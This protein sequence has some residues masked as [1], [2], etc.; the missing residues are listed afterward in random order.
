MWA[1]AIAVLVLLTSVLSSLQ[2]MR[3]KTF[4]DE[5][6]TATTHVPAT[7][8][9]KLVSIF[10]LMAMLFLAFSLIL[11]PVFMYQSGSWATGGELVQAWLPKKLHNMGESMANFLYFFAF[12]MVTIN[13]VF[14][15]YAHKKLIRDYQDDT[16]AFDNGNLFKWGDY[17][18]GVFWAMCVGATTLLVY[19]TYMVARNV[20]PNGGYAALGEGR[21]RARR[22]FRG[23]FSGGKRC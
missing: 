13:I 16:V 21:S 17:A 8:D 9:G 22:A 6:P 3:V 1:G 23:V 2:Y 18:E 10:T 14:S 15:A 7:D 12:S 19:S 11:I 4:L 5:A 20:M